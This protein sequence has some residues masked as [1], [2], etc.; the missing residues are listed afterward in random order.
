MFDRQQL[1][2]D[3]SG[4]M[5]VFMELKIPASD[6]MDKIEAVGKAK[7]F[8]EMAKLLN[9]TEIP[10]VIKALAI[11]TFNDMMPTPDG[12]QEQKTLGMGVLFALSISD[13]QKFATFALPDFWYAFGRG[14]GWD[15]EAVMPEPLIHFHEYI[16]VLDKI[17][18]KSLATGLKDISVAKERTDRVNDFFAGLL[19]KAKI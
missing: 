6:F 16:N 7:D 11:A 14:L 1:K 15:S 2:N 19:S 8:E 9:M 3:L 17:Y 12:L 18:H 4:L 13:M 10:L 5:E